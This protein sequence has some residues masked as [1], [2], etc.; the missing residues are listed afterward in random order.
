MQPEPGIATVLALVGLCA[1]A[2]TRPQID[3]LAMLDEADALLRVGEPEAA[4]KLLE[5]VDQDVYPELQKARYQLLHAQATYW[6]GEPW[7]AFQIVRRFPDA[8]PHS[9]L[10]LE[11]EQLV[12]DA[13]RQLS[14]SDSSF[15]IFA[16]DREDAR[17]VLEHLIQRYPRTTHLADA[18]RILG[19]M[20]FGDGNYSLAHTRFVD[21]LQQQPDSEWAGLARFRVAM[22]EFRV[23]QGPEYDLEQMGLARNELESFLNNPP[24]RPEFVS[25][26]RAALRVVIDWMAQRHLLVADFYK[27]LKNHDGE[28]HHLLVAAQEFPETDAGRTA[29]QKLAEMGAQGTGREDR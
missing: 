18:L 10:R 1:C 17:V 22:S 25:E 6:T 11:V 4:R 16:S 23:L 24:E 7:S 29:A 20:A 9:D 8:F 2:T 28:R 15:L 21:L 27:T 12:F 14:E 26:A 13:G 5:A 3:P 19:E